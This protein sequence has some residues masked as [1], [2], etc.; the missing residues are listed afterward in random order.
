MPLV[1]DIKTSD[2]RIAVWELTENASR[3]A[4]LTGYSGALPSHP[5]RQLER[6]AAYALL[7]SL[8]YPV[9]YR[10]NR[11]GRPFIPDS[12]VDISISHSSRYVA[13]AIASGKKV[14]VDIDRIDR[15]YAAV[16]DRFLTLQEA[17]SL[18]AMEQAC[19]ALRWCVKEAV[20]KLPH[21][22]KR[23]VFSRDIRVDI[24]GT[25]PTP[26]RVALK[27][28]GPEGWVSLGVNVRSFDNHIL[29]WVLR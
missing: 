7:A 18:G 28:F 1:K 23:P 13:I 5:R 26:E 16:A 14:G 29:A 19:L 27:L 22:D 24:T 4:A 2:C 17:Q 8:G 21:R 25:L 6:L 12:D 9:P 10:Y 11:L 15:N 3:L 20:F